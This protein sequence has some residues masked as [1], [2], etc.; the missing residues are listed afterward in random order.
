MTRKELD[1]R[2]LGKKRRI[3][4]VEDDVINQEIMKTILSDSYEVVVAGSGEEAISLIDSLYETISIV[5]LDLNLPKMSGIELLK[6]I[7][8]KS[9]YSSL[10]VIVLTA[11]SE[12]EVECLTLGAIDFI[13]KP[14]PLPKIILAR[15]LRVIELSEDRDIIQWT[16]HD[17]LTGLFN[18]DFFYRYVNQYD[19]YHKD[20][21]T[22][23]IVFDINNFHMINERYGKS[24]GD[25]ILKHIA[26]EARKLVEEIG[27]VVCRLDADTFMLYCAHCSDYESI[28]NRLS[29]LPKDDVGNNRVRMRMGVYSDVDK[30]VDIER[31]FDCAKM[32]AQ[33]VK[34][35]LTKPIEFYDHAMRE[36]E[37]LNEQL[38]DDFQ[39]AIDEKQFVIYYQ[40][41]FNVR[42]STPFL[43]SAEALVRWNH[44]KLGMVSPGV[45]I[46]LFENNGLIQKLDHYV[47]AETAAQIHRWKEKYGISIPVSVNVSRVDLY[48]SE[49]INR[50]KAIV[51]ENDLKTEDLYLEITESTYM[52]NSEKIV[53]K[54]KQLRELGFKI[55]MDD[56]GSGYSSLSMLSVLPIDVL[57]LDMQFVR[58]AF[59]GSKD[60]R[61]IDAI[62]KL[63]GSFG[64]NTVAEGVETEEQVVTLKA[65]G[66]DFIQGYYF[67]RPIPAKD[68]EKH[69][70]DKIKM[71]NKPK[72]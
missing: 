29:V 56:F 12:A 1:F 21:S 17:H 13:P 65:L 60:T 4:L 39:S 63:A 6:W 28:L 9:I 67:S 51:K 49:L 70:E 72:E 23:A 18:R 10:P 59:S 71:T 68:F 61:L 35:N 57:K 7:K 32:A 31:R 30:S 16:E 40:P 54:V 43:N 46:S 45:F 20:Q 11:D 62:I 5:L 41:K 47:W 19:L 27:G 37:I 15:I 52:D 55:E 3:L 34:G 36:S 33:S 8:N 53:E 14:Y 69:I 42:Q 64:I 24:F 48:D 50:L 2:I 26:N 38:I 22:D 25:D 58:S 66:C 44:P